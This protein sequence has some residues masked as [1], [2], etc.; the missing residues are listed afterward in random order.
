V[1][2]GVAVAEDARDVPALDALDERVFLHEAR[3]RPLIGNDL[4]AAG[5]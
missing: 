4:R 5:S 2:L 1:L 3:Q